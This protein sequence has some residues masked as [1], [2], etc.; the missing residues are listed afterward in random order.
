M[1]NKKQTYTTTFKTKVA[2]EAIKEEYTITEL[3]NKYNITPK[4][5]HNWKNIFLA[6]AELAMNP[7]QGLTESKK[8]IE[9]LEQKVNAYAKQLGKVTMENEFLVGKLQSLDLSSR[10]SMIDSKFNISLQKQCKL[11]KISR[12]SIYYKP[13]INVYK[14][15]L[16]SHLVKIHHDVS[17]YGYLKAH[18]L[19][20]ED[21]Y[22]ISQ[23]TVQ[24]YRK[25]LGIHA[26][27]AV[28]KLNLSKP[29]KGHTIYSYKLNDINISKSNHVWST[30]ITY[31][32]TTK[33]T[34]YLAAIIDWYSKAV[35]SYKIAN[36]MDKFLVI[37]VLNNAL[38]KYGTPEVFNT[39]Q[40]S[41]YTSDAHTQ[42]LKTKGI[43][44]S[45]DSKGRAT[46]NICIERFW[47]SAKYER[48]YL[49]QYDNII[50]LKKDIADYIDFYN[51][52]RFHQSINYAKPM[53]FY[54]NNLSIQQ[55]A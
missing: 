25:E 13:V 50:D 10:Q 48:I 29:N 12:T 37:D 9:D 31:L 17:C 14:E 32:K 2:I 45:M 16:K 54:Y 15:K 5:I 19:M 26:I 41:Q 21:G 36:T 24:K 7:A 38:D 8:I 47:R 33:G 53:E 28:K 42:I 52:K 49:N 30:D 27:L 55:V 46:D 44:I 39:D 20:Q 22:I 4:N 3:A 23:N 35:L 34:V 51:N 43:I 1:S 40:G 6:N 18:K 11:L